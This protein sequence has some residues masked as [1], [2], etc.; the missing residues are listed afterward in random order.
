MK[1]NFRY[2][3]ERESRKKQNIQE[4]VEYIL[5]MNYG[6]TI[7][8]TDL[9]KILGYNIEDENEEKKYRIIMQ[10]V[11][12]FI[13]EYGYV[14][15]GINGVGYYILKPSQI[16]K[17]CYKTYINRARRMY[18]KSDYILKHTE[19]SQLNEDR[20]EELQNMMELN[21][22]LIDNAWDTIKESAKDILKKV[23]VSD[24]YSDGDSKSIT[25]RLLFGDDE[26]TLTHDEVQKVVDEIIEKL[27]TK[28][29]NLKA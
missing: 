1:T 28:G 11:K 8:H 17:H 3:G 5:G 19:K 23:G 27:K 26:R 29:I 13:L 6:Q 22:K 7:F 21:K 20:L 24:V 14:L 18:D 9:S 10:R 12:N 15:K 4:V 25:V 16:S 2:T